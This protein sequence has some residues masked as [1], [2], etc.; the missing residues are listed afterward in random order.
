[1][2]FGPLQFDAPLWL[3]L[4]PLTWALTIWWGRNSLTGMGSVTRRVAL[5]MRLLLLTAIVTALADPQWRLVSKDVATVM[6]VDKSRSMPQ[7]VHERLHEYVARALEH[8]K[9]TDRLGAVTTAADALTQSLPEPVEPDVEQVRMKLEGGSAMIG[10]ESATDL[11][12]GVRLAMSMIPG[13]A[14]GRLTLVSD[15]NETQGSLLTAA[16]AAAA[17]GIPIDVLP[18]PYQYGR[19]VIFDGLYAP[20]TAR[21]GQTI[22][23]RMSLTAKAPTTGELTLMMGDRPVDLSPDDPETFGQ[24][25]TLNEG[26]NTLMVPVT[27][28]RSGAQEFRAFFAPI[29]PES[30]AIAENNTAAGVTFVAAEGTVLLIADNPRAA[31]PLIDAMEESR[32]GV[33]ARPSDQ[34]PRSLAE[35]QE[36]DAI[37]LMDVPAYAFDFAQQREMAS[38]VRDAGG[39]LVMIGGVNSFGS[40]GW[41]GSPVAEV[42][43]VLLEPPQKRNIPKGALAMIMHSIEIPNGVYLGKQTAK[44]AVGALSSRD[45][46]GIIEYSWS[47]GNANGTRWIYPMQE[48]GDGTAAN[49]AIANMNFGDMPDYG[50]P[51][52]AALN[53]LSNVKAGQKHL[54]MVTDGD[55]SMPSVALINQF[56]AQK[57][58]ITTVCVDPHGGANDATNMK[59]LANVTGGNSYLIYSQSSGNQLAQLPEIFIKEAQTVKRSLIWEGDPFNPK[60]VNGAAEA[61]RGIGGSLPAMTG[62]IVTADREGLALTTARTAEDDPLVAQWQHG[63]G[64]SVAFTSDA[65]PRWSSD[66]VSWGQ[67]KQFW[68]QHIRWAMRPTGA[69][70]LNV[71]TET[72]GDSTHVVVTALDSSGDPL[73]F[74]AFRGAVVD[75]T[76]KPQAFELTQTAPGRYEGDFAS[77]KPGTHI[78]TLR[79]D[80]AAVEGG[81]PDRGSVQAAVLRPYPDEYR[82]LEDNAPLLRQVAELTG[83]RVLPDDDPA[84]A[85]LFSRAGLTMPVSLRSIWLVVALVS[86]GLFLADVAVRRVRI[87]L[88]AMLAWARGLFRR[89]HATATQVDALRAARQTTRQKLAERSAKGDKSH[90]EPAATPGDRSRKFEAGD[91]YL[92]KPARSVTD[93]PP[94]IVDK[95]AKDAEPPR[96]G[97]KGKSGAEEGGMSRLLA[98]KKRA[99][100]QMKDEDK[101]N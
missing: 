37:V 98:A 26:V 81:E 27:V 71:A 83:G 62:Y 48:K 67:Y 69:A 22:N 36:F 18:V 21:K 17:A 77:N 79:Y 7:G 12:S 16:R 49:A 8:S 31:Q 61:M 74:A 15:G 33:E 89:Q 94:P 96:A 29:D 20:A 78:V 3:V 63:L 92:K 6:I 82:A 30:D 101:K 51:M 10:L 57:I 40:G 52:Q 28:A 86:L 64:R 43:P 90:R 58:T 50:A 2:I 35:L 88:P 80:A 45:E 60:V 47:T 32:I 65:A 99:Q 70:N 93:A 87:D 97:E 14:A 75:P 73:N 19:E 1:M 25:Y 66:W 44:A 55:A 100:D 39:G 34:A 11:A 95:R 46:V 59:N 54:I 56:V 23:V 4:I 91:E 9:K 53:A 72:R 76:L 85:D 41:I 5:G 38:Y 13:D 24:M 68:E 84:N 42:L